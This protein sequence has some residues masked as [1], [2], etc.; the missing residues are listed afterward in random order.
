MRAPRPVEKS[1]PPR[2]PL[3]KCTLSANTSLLR[4][5]Q[6]VGHTPPADSSRNQ[7][8]HKIYEVQE[9][10]ENRQQHINPCLAGNLRPSG[11]ECFRHANKADG[12]PDGGEQKRQK[13]ERQEMK[14]R[15]LRKDVAQ[16][17]ERAES[18]GQAVEKMRGGRRSP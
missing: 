9:R 14:S 5:D 18:E 6:F 1:R 10:N 3:S 12:A 11:R 7:R 2:P 17:E 13:S 15:P 16:G 4:A 8:I